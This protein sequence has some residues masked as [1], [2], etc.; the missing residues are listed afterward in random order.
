VGEV[1]G[2]LAYRCT[3]VSEPSWPVSHNPSGLAGGVAL[4]VPLVLQGGSDVGGARGDTFFE[5]A[6]LS[7][8]VLC[9]GPGSLVRLSHSRHGGVTLAG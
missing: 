8:C 4:L 9:G 3:A 1:F 2:G 5:A 7:R 6:G